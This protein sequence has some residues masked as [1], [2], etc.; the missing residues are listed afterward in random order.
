MCIGLASCNSNSKKSEIVFADNPVIAHRGA[1]KAKGLPKNSI[2]A[3]K[4]AINQKCTV[5]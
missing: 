5:R 4:E 2:A 3:L 1:W